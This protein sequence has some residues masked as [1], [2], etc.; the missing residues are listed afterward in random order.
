MELLIELIEKHNL[1][2]Y[3]ICSG[4]HRKLRLL[5]Q[6]EF[7]NQQALSFEADTL[8]DLFSQAEYWFKHNTLKTWAEL[9][10]SRA[11]NRPLTRNPN[12]LRNEDAF[13]NFLDNLFSARG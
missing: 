2:S 8:P 3:T 6:A 13:Q 9:A 1:R 7:I 10:R 12:V 11:V 4:N 5:I